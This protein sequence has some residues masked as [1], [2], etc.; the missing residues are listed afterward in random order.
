MPKTATVGFLVS[1][2]WFQ[3]HERATCDMGYFLKSMPTSKILF[4]RCA[5]GLAKTSHILCPAK[6]RAAQLF[7][8]QAYS[9]I[10]EMES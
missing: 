7:F 2:R 5:A 1:L 8:S 6:N 4:N 10:S 9:Q 3:I